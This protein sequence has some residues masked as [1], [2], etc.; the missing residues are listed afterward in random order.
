MQ[1]RS[2]ARPGSALSGSVLTVVMA[3]FL[4][5]QSAH[6]A[7]T[8]YSHSASPGFARARALARAFNEDQLHEEARQLLLQGFSESLL[9]D[10]SSRAITPALKAAYLDELEKLQDENQ[11]LPG[12]DSL[13]L[14]LGLAQLSLAERIR[15][16][17]ILKGAD[18]VKTRAYE[19]QT[20]ELAGQLIS[21]RSV[22]QGEV[23]QLLIVAPRLLQESSL[24]ND[25][26]ELYRL[27]E[28]SYPLWVQRF[29]ATVD[30]PFVPPTAAQ[31]HDLYF[32]Q[33]STLLY[34]D[35]LYDQKPKLFLFCRH[36]RQYPCLLVMK[37][38]HGQPVFGP[39]DE[40]P[41]F[42]GKLWS[43][44]RLA[45][46]KYGKHF[47]E[48]NGYTPS[49]IYQ[50]DGVMP[51]ANDPYDFGK[52]RRVVLNFIE[53]S[54]ETGPLQNELNFQLLLPPSNWSLNGWRESI[55]ARELGR[56]SFRLHGTG[57]KN[58]NRE[59]T[60]Y[61]FIPTSGCIAARENA[62]PEET[63][64]DQRHLLDQ[65]MLASELE[66][67]WSN[68]TEITAL[69]YVIEINDFQSPVSLTDLL[70]YGIH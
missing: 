8:A 28:V 21:S 67:V 69:L 38:K 1:K 4:G 55:I 50:I 44:P 54:P 2:M 36:S 22:T 56:N 18:N 68:E 40:I 41:R 27:L 25:W 49:G 12:F 15:A 14:Q 62:Y 3:V 23:D 61:P 60:Y 13:D 24:R 57:Q 48:T 47:D 30:A 63:Y 53:P 43:Q 66:P 64:L 51:E 46:S 42:P 34:R 6:S 10:L 45:L 65:L 5:A 16:L 35:G 20:L 33:T 31:I 37:D 19:K 9:L 39:F 17:Q 26:S 52:F 32:N 11:V 29:H 70:A 58:S 7:Q 59:S